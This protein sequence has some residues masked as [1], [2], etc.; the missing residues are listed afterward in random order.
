MRLSFHIGR[1]NIT[2]IDTE[3]TDY[4]FSDCSDSDL[5]DMVDPCLGGEKEWDPVSQSA[6]EERFHRN[7]VNDGYYD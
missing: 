5:D 2:I 4:D 7:L 1:T 6:F 3:T